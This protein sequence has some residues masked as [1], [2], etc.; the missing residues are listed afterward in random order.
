MALTTRLQFNVNAN[1]SSTVGLAAA[2]AVVQKIW[3]IDL[4]TGTGANQAD[5]VYSLNE[6][7]IADGQ[8]L[9]ID[10]AA[11]LEDP[12]GGAFTPVR[13]KAIFLYAATTNTTNLTILGDAASV[14]FLNTAATTITLRPGAMFA[15]ADPGA[16]GWTV[17]GTTADIVQIVNGSGAA[18][19]VS[20]VIIGASA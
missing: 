4:A 12:L 17:T 20:V 6:Q 1:L 5:K 8:T 19:K 13:V 11:S 3:T 9:D 7:S 10:L 14:L 16:T 2:Q 15:L 18:A